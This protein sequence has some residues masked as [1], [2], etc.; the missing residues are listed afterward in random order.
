MVERPATQANLPVSGLTGSNFARSVRLFFFSPLR[1]GALTSAE[2]RWLVGAA[3]EDPTDGFRVPALAP[4]GRIPSAC[5]TSQISRSAKWSSSPSWRP[6]ARPASLWP[7]DSRLPVSPAARCSL[8]AKVERLS[9]R[10][11]RP[12]R[13]ITCHRLGSG[14]TMDPVGTKTA[15]RRQSAKS[16]RHPL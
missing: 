16:G 4:F 11:E 8:A 9:G 6:R 10:V 7:Q 3:R 5:R 14:A 2:S 1:G 15:R 13:A 12:E